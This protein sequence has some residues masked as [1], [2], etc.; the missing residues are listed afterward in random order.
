M[1]S[2]YQPDFKN[3]FDETTNYTSW[4]IQ[5]QLIKLCADIRE[6]IVKEIEK[7]GFFALMCD[8]AKFVLCIFFIKLIFFNGSN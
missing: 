3:K 2:N 8:E 4:S 6:T 7:I 1:L 5:D